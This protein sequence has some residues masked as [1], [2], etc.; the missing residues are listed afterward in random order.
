MDLEEGKLEHAATALGHQG[1][2]GSTAAKFYIDDQAKLQ[3][4]K[5]NMLKRE[6]FK[7]KGLWG[8]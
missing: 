8:V 3:N 1:A 6:M 7:R 5:T 2:K 4:R